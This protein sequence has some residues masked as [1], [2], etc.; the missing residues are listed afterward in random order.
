MSPG[1]RGS[2]KLGCSLRKLNFSPVSIMYALENEHVWEQVFKICCRN[3]LRFGRYLYLCLH[4]LVDMVIVIA[5]L[6]PVFEEQ[7]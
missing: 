4:A 5:Y 6:C 3:S 1:R 2:L 7:L